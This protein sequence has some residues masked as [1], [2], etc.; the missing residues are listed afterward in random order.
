MIFYTYLHFIDRLQDEH[1]KLQQ[2]LSKVHQSGS[3][4]SEQMQNLIKTL[5]NDIAAKSR[6]V[7]KSI[8]F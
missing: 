7:R 3:V 8:Y 2:T 4:T 5:Q 6:E 1:V